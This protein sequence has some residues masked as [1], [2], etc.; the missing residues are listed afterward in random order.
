MQAR[1]KKR[2]PGEIRIQKDIAELDGGRIAT[3]TFPDP[4]DLTKFNVEVR[5]YFTKMLYFMVSLFKIVINLSRSNQILDT[6]KERDTCS[7]LRFLLCILMNPQKFTARPRHEY[8]NFFVIPLFSGTITLRFFVI[9]SLPSLPAHQIYH[10]NINA[11]G[12]VCLN[13]LRE[14]WKPVLGAKL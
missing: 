12:N 13:I 3:V 1:T 9:F 2:T 4:N 6:G 7:H 8:F 5:L 11:E 10:P 14:D